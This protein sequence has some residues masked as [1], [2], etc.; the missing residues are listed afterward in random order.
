MEERKKDKE[1]M[2]MEEK[3][4]RKKDKEQ[5]EM[6]EKEE[7]QTRTKRTRR[8]RMKRKLQRRNKRRKDKI[9]RKRRFVSKYIIVRKYNIKKHIKLATTIS[10]QKKTYN[11]NY[12]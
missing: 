3:E 8:T 12:R 11:F 5:M 9:Q 2:E 10:V 6:E 1:K 4:E 7:K